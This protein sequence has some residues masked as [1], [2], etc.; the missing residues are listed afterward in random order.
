MRA[1]RWLYPFLSFVAALAIDAQQLDLCDPDDY[2]EPRLTRARVVFISRLVTCVSRGAMDPYRPFGQDVGAIHLANSLYWSGLQLDFKR[3]EMRGE[4]GI[5]RDS[6]IGRFAIDADSAADTASAPAPVPGPKNVAQ[7]SWYQT[8]GERLSFRYRFVHATQLA[9]RETTANVAGLDDRDET[10][11]FQVD[12]GRRS[13]GR[14]QFVTLSYSVLTRHGT[15][16]GSK[17][18]TLTAATILPTI[19]IG[20]GFLTPRLLVGGVADEGRTIDLYNASLDW[21]M[22]IP[23]VDANVHLVYSPVYRD[24]GGGG[25]VHHQV[26]IYADRA[27]LVLARRG[28]N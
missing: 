27:L 22:H 26:A 20:P 4:H 9:Q 2:V 17:Q 5:E 13:G 12:A 25:R 10:R 7:I 1:A 19:R 15:I 28:R 16:A 23:R 21:S 6:D 24:L 3:T 14:T 8:A 11:M 18:R